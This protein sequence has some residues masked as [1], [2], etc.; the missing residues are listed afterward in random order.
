MAHTTETYFLTAL[1]PGDPRS[2]DQQGL[3][4]ATFVLCPHVTLSRTHHSLSLFFSTPTGL[5]PR[6][7]DLTEPNYLLEGSVSKHSCPE[8]QG[9]NT[10]TSRG[11]NSVCNS[12]D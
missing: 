4:K 1:E 11:H 5:G 3:Q 7:C 9:F 2:R 6:L 8:G 10:H 12:T